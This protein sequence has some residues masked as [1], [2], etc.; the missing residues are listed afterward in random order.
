MTAVM[1]K[2]C[3][4]YNGLNGLSSLSS[5]SS[6]K[7]HIIYADQSL[8]SLRLLHTW[9]DIKGKYSIIYIVF[10]LVM[11]VMPMMTKRRKDYVFE[12][13]FRITWT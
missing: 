9:L 11:T 5:L 1:T 6:L 8:G 7:K 3:K 13:V 10:I 2:I 12:R 4:P